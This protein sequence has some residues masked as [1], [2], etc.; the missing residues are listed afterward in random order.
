MQTANENLIGFLKENP[1]SNKGTIGNGTGLKGL[2]LFNLLKKLQKEKQ[3][4]S[5]GDGQNTAY[6]LV[7]ETAS[8]EQTGAGQT[9]TTDP[10][11]EEPVTDIQTTVTKKSAGRD[12][13]K[14]TFNGEAYG[15][16]PLAR[17]VVAQYVKDNPSITYK[18]LKEVFPDSLLKRFGIFQE[19]KSAR[20]I[21]KKGERYFF[22][23]GHI[24]KLKEN[25]I[26]VCNQFTTDNIQPFLKV[27][28]NLGYNIKLSA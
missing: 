6:S 11:T 23:E 20:E 27:A 3:I 24:I 17:T 13:S 1:N 7:E 9:E 2:V 15:K 19:E 26:V 28:K 10:M 4:T 22:K 8:T 12:N 18:Q 5:H 14:F 21:A 16:G 25:N